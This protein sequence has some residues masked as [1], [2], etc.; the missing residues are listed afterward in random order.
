MAKPLGEKSK[1]IRE[2]ITAHP[3]KNSKA[4]ADLLNKAPE[5]ANDKIR[6]SATDVTLQRKAMSKGS[7]GKAAGKP[8]R[9]GTR[10]QSQE[11]AAASVVALAS[12]APAQGDDLVAAIAA[13]KQLVGAYG[14]G[15]IR[16]LVDL[17]EK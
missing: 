12:T 13:L 5:R 14:A 4:I 7:N 9:K 8:G 1:L 11:T 6:V 15:T 16:G 17:L 2:A 10:A 3:R